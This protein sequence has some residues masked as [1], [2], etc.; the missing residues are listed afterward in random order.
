M[1][2]PLVNHFYSPWFIFSIHRHN[3]LSDHHCE[4][5]EN[6]GLIN[7]MFRLNSTRPISL[8]T[9][10][11]WTN[12]SLRWSKIAPCWYLS[13]PNNTLTS[14]SHIISQTWI[15]FR[16]CGGR[17]KKMAALVLIINWFALLI[18]IQNTK[19]FSPGWIIDFLDFFLYH[20][21][22]NFMQNP[23]T[24]RKVNPRKWETKNFPWAYTLVTPV[25]GAVLGTGSDAGWME[26]C[27]GANAKGIGEEPAV[28]P[29]TL[30]AH[31]FH[32][33]MTDERMSIG[34]SIFI[35][36]QISG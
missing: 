31:Y 21:D 26:P 15:H 2:N 17:T 25:Q 14:S 6:G 16:R 10:N 12:C 27:R 8:I 23:N 1:T 19:H 5:Y 28:L 24:L 29:F 20:F 34:N 9:F 30:F 33:L 36:F 18:N 7:E 35:Q 11:I 13:Q 4:F 22:W 32:P 3:R